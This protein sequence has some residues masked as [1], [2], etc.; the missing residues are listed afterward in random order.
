M[1]RSV[2]KGALI[3][4]AG[5]IS[6][7]I[8]GAIFRILLPRFI[9]G[10]GIGIY[11]LAYSI[12]AI[13]FVLAIP[14]IQLAMSKLIAQEEA[15]G[16]PDNSRA[17]FA[18]ILCSLA[19]FGLFAATL[20]YIL[21]DFLAVRVLGD[22][23]AALPLKALAPSILLVWIISAFRGFFQGKQAMAP[24]ALSMI[25][26]Q[27]AR[28]LF[29]L[30]FFTTLPGLSKGF[31]AAGASL[32]TFAGATGA[33]TF[34]FAL[35]L[36]R[37]KKGHEKGAAPSINYL[38]LGKKVIKLAFPITIGAIV[39]SSAS[40]LDAT[41]IPRRLQEMGLSLAQARDQFGQM[42]G[43]AL[44]IFNLP[45]VFAIS[46]ALSLVPAVSE[47]TALQ[48]G[49]RLQGLIRKAYKVGL[50]LVIPSAVG[51]FVLGPELCQLLFGYRQAGVI[52]RYLCPGLLFSGAQQVAA[53]I[54][55][56]LGKTTLPA[57]NLLAGTI[58]AGILTFL[59]TGR[60][61]INGAAAA[62]V[63]GMGLAAIL[64][65]F[66][67]QKYVDYKLNW[68]GNVL[69]PA[70]AGL[71]MGVMI[72]YISDTIIHLN[73]SIIMALFLSLTAGGLLYILL[74]MLFGVLKP[75]D[76]EEIPVVGL[77]V[78]RYF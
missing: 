66:S 52:L 17:I 40:V 60:Y 7:R 62:K 57:R 64:N 51:L 35:Y 21:S 48:Q 49:K 36:I 32:G 44:A 63:M 50:F 10:E 55:Q 31:L 3:L 34:L 29:V 75:N 68:A 42:T 33:L 69:K 67:L 43:M 1:G 73:G 19:I 56:G 6:A 25:V 26:E 22:P 61:G 54:L 2:L 38:A 41:I 11:H 16:R 71:L 78:S 4:S 45:M 18:T 5:G 28:V 13:T 20:L 70:L 23:A 58:M 65:Y 76:L 8:I 72:Y 47:A 59:F 24:Y 77:W 14:G 15:Q 9:G 53:G 37:N 74:S 39:V 30:F 46:L 27:S 12:Y